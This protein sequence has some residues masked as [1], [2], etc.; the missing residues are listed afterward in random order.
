[1]E[2]FIRDRADY[3]IFSANGY[4]WREDGS[5]ELVYEPGD[6]PDSMEFSD[7][8]KECF[9]S[10]GAAYRRELFDAV[11]GYRIGVFGEDYDFWLRAV[12]GGARHAYL[13]KPLSL[14]R[15]SSTQKSARMVEWCRSDI[16]LLSDIRQHPKLTVSE[17]EAVDEG[18]RL[19]ER[20]L[21]R[22]RFDPL[23]RVVYRAWVGV[24]TPFVGAERAQSAPSRVKA[25]VRERFARSSRQSDDT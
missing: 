15:L 14:H 23:R 25:A 11:G 4:W 16:R 2:R 20:R 18:I 17:R 24:A 12:A 8:T 9:Y 1:M 5:R 22:V 19:R 21:S 6:I 7:L 3:D 13:D 10:V